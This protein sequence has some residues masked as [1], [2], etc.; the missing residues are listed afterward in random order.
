[1]LMNI[2]QRRIKIKLVGKILYLVNNNNMTLYVPSTEFQEFP[3]PLSLVE[4]LE[5]WTIATD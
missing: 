5:S 1:M 4:H 2:E 3:A